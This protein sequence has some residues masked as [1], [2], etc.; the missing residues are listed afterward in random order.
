MLDFD[1][2]SPWNGASLADHALQL[3]QIFHA[4]SLAGQ[5]DTEKEVHP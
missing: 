3:M 1:I 2:K 4:R 5:K